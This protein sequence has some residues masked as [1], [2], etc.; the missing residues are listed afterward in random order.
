N[1]LAEYDTTIEG[2]TNADTVAVGK[3]NSLSGNA[4]LNILDSNVTANV[5]GTGK[6]GKKIDAKNG[7][8][9]V[10]ANSTAD[11]DIVP[12]GIAITTGGTVA[13]AGNIGVNVI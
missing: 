4:V 9:N 6:E 8:I 5:T 1:V 3:G 11:I 13:A 2:I 10:Q 12:V 7:A